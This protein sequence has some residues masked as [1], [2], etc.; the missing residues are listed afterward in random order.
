MF[1]VMPIPAFND[2]YIWALTVPGST[3]VAVVDPGDADVVEHYLNENNLLLTTILITHHH[4]DHTG[5]VAQL[6]QDNTV[7]V[8]GPA[9]SPF[10][11][12]THK[13]SD[14]DQISLM[15]QT[16]TIREV[17]GHTLDHI[18]YYLPGS[19][20]QLFCGDTLFLAGCG[21]LFEGS[22][23]QMHRA[24]E[25]FRQLPDATQIYC[26]HEY[27]LANLAFAAAVEPANN[28]IKAAIEHCTQLRESDQPTLPTDIAT[29]KQI[30]PFLRYSEA[31]VRQ[32]A[33]LFAGGPLTSE[34]A[35][36]AM[37]REWKNQF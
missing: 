36:F 21:R 37:I 17:P 9:N 26:T 18:S 35:I 25:Y 27:S 33:E 13:L 15:E 8:Y 31:P 5:G 19:E 16:L 6:C 30:N 22:A 12:I 4:H 29:E 10:D 11:G 14:G 1:N 2:N 34:V 32:S 23:E 28:R 3:E 24:M 20:P 7:T